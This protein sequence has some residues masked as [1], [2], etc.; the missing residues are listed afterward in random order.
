MAHSRWLTTAS[1]IL[2]LYV[3]TSEPSE[4]LIDIVTYIMQVY[5]PMWFAIKCSANFIN[6]AK[7]VFHQIELSTKL[8]DQT[9]KVTD[10]VIQRNA[11]F[12][13][14]ENIIVTMMFD[15]KKPMR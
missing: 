8:N 13:N 7:Q 2:C 15:E 11:F 10:K 3:A 4:K 9:R 14:P 5:T 12:A 1:R 6:G